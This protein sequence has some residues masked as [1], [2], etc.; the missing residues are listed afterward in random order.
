MAYERKYIPV[1]EIDDSGNNDVPTPFPPGEKRDIAPLM[2][3]GGRKFQIGRRSVAGGYGFWG[4]PQSK[5]DENSILIDDM[6]PAQLN[7]AAKTLTRHL[8]QQAIT[9]SQYEL[10]LRIANASETVEEC[11]DKFWDEPLLTMEEVGPTELVAGDEYDSLV[12]IIARLTEVIGEID[13][14]TI[15]K[16]TT[17]G[18]IENLGG[19]EILPPTDESPVPSDIN[20][21]K[22]KIA[23][24]EQEIAPAP[25]PAPSAVPVPD[26]VPEEIPEV[27]TIPIPEGEENLTNA[28]GLLHS[29]L[30]YLGTARTR[31]DDVN[32][33]LLGLMESLRLLFQEL[34]AGE[35]REAHTQNYKNHLDALRAAIVALSEAGV[36]YAIAEYTRYLYADRGHFPVGSD[37]WEALTRSPNMQIVIDPNGFIVDIWDAESKKLYDM[38]GNEIG[39]RSTPYPMPSE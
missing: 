3:E 19:Q 35:L 26:E 21:L 4:S 11:N 33:S 6:T 16:Q 5:V 10:M 22:E 20:Q 27:P 37:A 1:T 30:N 18:E 24:I 39:T 7:E 31:Q 23:E 36:G 29:I 34:A 25:G 13:A 15:A 38:H 12:K 17:I 9:K 28:W 8:K 2:W 32:N 14:E